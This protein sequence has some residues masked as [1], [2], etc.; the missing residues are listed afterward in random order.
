MHKNKFKKYFSV[1]LVEHFKLKKTKKIFGHSLYAKKFNKN[2][3]SFPLSETK[4]HYLIF[5]PFLIFAFLF[6][7]VPATLHTT[8]LKKIIINKN[9]FVIIGLFKFI[10]FIFFAKKFFFRVC[11]KNA[12]MAFLALLGLKIFFGAHEGV[13]KSNRMDAKKFF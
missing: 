13:Y 10:N 11:A 5:S 8:I 2:I 12:N 7:L 3:H 4:K 6:L 9:F 1:T